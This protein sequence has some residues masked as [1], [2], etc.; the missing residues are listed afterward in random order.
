MFQRRDRVRPRVVIAGMGDTGILVAIHL[1][2]RFQVTGIATRPALLSGQEL[3]NRLADPTHWRRNFLIPFPSF[4]RLDD[5]TV[6]HGR[7]AAVDEAGCAVTVERAD[8]TETTEPYDVLVI[9][10]GATNGFWRHDRVEDLTQ[11]ERSLADVTTQID[12][13]ATIA[14]VGGGATGVSAA[15][16]LARRHPH[17]AVHLFVSGDQPLP[18]YHPRVRTRMA[19]DLAAAGVHVHPGHRAAVPDG[20]LGDRL[21]TT[22]SEWSTGQGPFS[23]DVVLWALG[24]VRPNNGFIP[25][26]MLDEHGFVRVDEHLRVPGHPN[27]YAVGDVAA[28]D[29]HRSSAR[30]WGYLV[31]ARNIRAQF[32]HGKPRRYKAPPT[33]WG[34]IAGLQDD[35]LTVFQPNGKAFTVPKWAVQPLLFRLYLHQILYGGL[36]RRG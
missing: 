15:M 13:A 26:E 36:R 3:G 29:P 21:T 33:R 30:N 5:V 4:K 1:R 11:V 9:A 2:R 34:S 18:G 12:A 32:G 28:S 16:N 10:S 23:A 25:P 6:L 14:V 8:G 35:G 22:P 7:I 24:R 27:V 17:K 31:V 20:F 19:N